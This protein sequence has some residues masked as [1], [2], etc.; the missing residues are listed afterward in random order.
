M[1]AS[2]SSVCPNG[3][4]RPPFF[5][6]PRLF[7][8]PGTMHNGLRSMKWMLF[9]SSVGVGGALGAITA[10]TGCC[11][12]RPNGQ[13]R[14]H[15]M[16]ESAWAPPRSIC[17]REVSASGQACPPLIR[18]CTPTCTGRL[19]CGVVRPSA[20]APGS[21]PN[22]AHLFCS[23]EDAVSSWDGGCMAGCRLWRRA[24]GWLTSLIQAIALQRRALPTSHSQSPQKL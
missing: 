12:C 11:T 18:P 5:T 6:P 21:G 9:V 24:P 16:N 8:Y 2:V 19:G 14:P 4:L 13:H 1:S 3:S 10:A 23:D 7:R 17:P 22:R 20:A 15:A